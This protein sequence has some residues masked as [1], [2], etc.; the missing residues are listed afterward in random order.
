M[1]TNYKDAMLDLGT[2]NHLRVMK[3][4]I[5]LHLR[6]QDIFILDLIK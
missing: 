6:L 5:K 2:S 3:S 1:P 4:Y